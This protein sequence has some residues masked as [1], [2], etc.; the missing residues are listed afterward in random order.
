MNPVTQDPDG[1]AL[2]LCI[3][4][5]LLVVLLIAAVVEAYLER[6]RSRRHRLD[7][8][9]LARCERAGSQGENQRR[10]RAAVGR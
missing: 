3:L 2:M 8:V 9:D 7:R 1:A 5:G 6:R 10:I 4:L